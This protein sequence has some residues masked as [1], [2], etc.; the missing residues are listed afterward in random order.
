M[1]HTDNT[2][3]KKISTI[4]VVGLGY[5]GL[6]LLR[7]LVYAYYNDPSVRIIG[8]DLN[9][10]YVHNLLHG[11]DTRGI[12]PADAVAEVLT[13]AEIY[14][15][16]RLVESVDMCMVC[17]PTPVDDDD[18][19]DYSALDAACRSIGNI[20]SDNAIICIESTVA[21]GTTEGRCTNNLRSTTTLRPV[22][23][24]MVYSPE[25]VNPSPT[26]FD[27]MLEEGSKLV[28]SY[29]DS[30]LDTAASVYG[31]VFA[32]VTKV[33][34]IQAAEL[35]KVF[36][37]AQRDVN[38]AMAN[39]LS[40]ICRGAGIPLPMVVKS[41]QTKVN[42]MSFTSGIVGGHC[43]PVDPHYLVQW[44][45]GKEDYSI[46]EHGRD[47]HARYM[48]LLVRL[49]LDNSAREPARVLIMGA[50]YK[51]DVNDRRNAGAKRLAEALH[52]YKTEIDYVDIFDVFSGYTHTKKRT[53]RDHLAQPY[54]VV[55][56]LINHT[57][58]SNDVI[59]E[60][61]PLSADCTFINVGG[62]SED[63]CHGIHKIINV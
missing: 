22:R 45:Y 5:V 17:V 57:C 1:P 23:F 39:E 13:H 49:I 42:A 8:L 37:N 33:H 58:A 24:D 3:V 53:P 14:S 60:T 54:N 59:A 25:R 47:I 2:A 38:I 48:E 62:F 34:D 7:G 41:L 31:K 11:T 27:D 43:I 32:R 46:F 36:E 51:R 61:Y 18:M 21:P 4:C 52:R 44:Y 26:S 30:A 9:E 28:A 50:T 35:A 15:D 19:P 63:Q 12:L 6:P 40:L 56:G 29:S 20:I 10:S 55:V 16:Y